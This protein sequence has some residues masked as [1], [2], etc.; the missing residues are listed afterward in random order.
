MSIDLIEKPLQS[1]SAQ[2]GAYKLNLYRNGD[3]AF[4]I[5]NDRLKYT[6]FKEILTQKMPG[7]YKDT[8]A[9]KKTNNN[10]HT[11]IDK[12]GYLLD[13]YFIAPPGTKNFSKLKPD[14]AIQGQ[15]LIYL[16]FLD[17]S[18]NIYFTHKGFKNI[19]GVKK[20]YLFEY[21]KS[22]GLLYNVITNT[23]ENVKPVNLHA[24]LSIPIYNYFGKITDALIQENRILFDEQYMSTRKSYASN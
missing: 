19:G 15:T 10:S 11:V 3:I 2:G 4:Y 12:L 9:L 21:T 20:A 13:D 1:F 6:S 14:K 16:Q 23:Y 24:N 18:T 8:V 7:K 5:I 17:N 22:K